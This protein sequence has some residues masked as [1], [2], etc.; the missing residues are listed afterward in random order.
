MLEK[1]TD[2]R[3]HISGE[4]ETVVTTTEI[5]VKSSLFARPASTIL[6]IEKLD[7]S[8]VSAGYHLH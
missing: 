1:H 6:I 3:Q 8:C 7:R 5:Y 2:N 4:T